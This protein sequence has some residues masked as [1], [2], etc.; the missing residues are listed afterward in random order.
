M[1]PDAERN[2]LTES[3]EADLQ[4][5]LK[6]SSLT[7]VAN[8]LPVRAEVVEDGLNWVPSPG[9]LVSAL[10]PALRS[11]GTPTW[12]GWADASGELPSSDQYEGFKIVPVDLTALDV[13]KY[14]EG[15]SNATIWPLFHDS[16]EIPTYHR[17]WWESYVT[18]NQKFADSVAKVAQPNSIVWVHDYQLQLVPQMLRRERPD[19]KIGFFLHIPFPA[20]EL[21]MRL[22]WRADIVRGILGADVVGF[23]TN[24]SKEY[25]LSA[26]DR[27]ANV[28][29][30]EGV[31]TIEGRQVTV[32]AFPVGIDFDRIID[33]ATAEATTKRVAEMRHL[34]GDPKHVIL[35]VDRLDYTKGIELRLRALLELLED[36]RI[37]PKETVIIQIAEPSRGG[38][39]GYARIKREVEQIAGGING[40]HADLG[41]PLLEY[42]HRSVALEELVALYRLADVML[43]TPFADGMNLV[44][45]EYAAS[46]TDLHGVL[47][48]SEFAGAAQE[49]SAALLVNP[50]DINGVKDTI[51]RALA[52]PP[53]EQEERMRTLNREVQSST[54]AAW[55]D[56]FLKLL[57]T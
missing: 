52:M 10:T 41:R 3:D 29:V 37:D 18:V 5:R 16:I 53:E 48:L 25:F 30:A 2:D 45:K 46:R 34:F 36:G 50:Y 56:S 14:Y 27:T 51:V 24:V 21:F 44:A 12:V 32:G 55:A 4:H 11:A 15:F 8:R 47:V 17:S 57:V 7:I 43:V 49:L 19:L 20:P 13:E 22:P 9:G 6:N 1:R 40:D 23:Q 39:R 28:A 54:V 31:V 38:T 33:A 35:G 42:H 26:A